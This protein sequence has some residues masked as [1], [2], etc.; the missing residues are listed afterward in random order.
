MPEQEQRL[1]DMIVIQG[2]IARLQALP[3]LPTTQAPV[4]GDRRFNNP[5]EWWRSMAP[6]F[7]WL[8]PLARYFALF[9]CIVCI[10][11]MPL[12]LHKGVPCYTC[13][14]GACRASFLRC[15]QRHQRQAH[16]PQ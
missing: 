1:A 2:E 11:H 8:A 15:G 16:A 14:M 5:L 7:P 9:P 10:P 6:N 4:S 12:V 13:D 3:V